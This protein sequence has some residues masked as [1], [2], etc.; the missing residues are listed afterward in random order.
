[1]VAEMDSVH[2]TVRTNKGD[3]ILIQR[4]GPYVKYLTSQLCLSVARIQ[5]EQG[6][7][8]IAED[9]YSINVRYPEK[10]TVGTMKS[11]M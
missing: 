5:S 4:S 8:I 2:T 7:L 9:L 1:M 6:S 10:A 11:V 3:G